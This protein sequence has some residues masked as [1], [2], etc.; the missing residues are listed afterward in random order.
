MTISIK[1]SGTWIPDDIVADH[2]LIFNNKLC[3]Q[4][5]Y[6]KAFMDY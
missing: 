5:K 4:Y 2:V 1:T 6:V 3:V